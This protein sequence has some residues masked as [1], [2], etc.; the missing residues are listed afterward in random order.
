MSLGQLGNHPR[1]I[2][3]IP[4]KAYESLAMGLPYLT[5][6]NKGILELL[7][8]GETCVVCNPADPNSLAEKI[9]WAK[10][11]WQELERIAERGHNL[12]IDKLAPQILAAE[13]LE[14]IKSL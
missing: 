1:L 14:S 6:A 3:T 7:K 13:L 9:L 12:F 5:A 8:D 11:N 10:N 2:R 4:H